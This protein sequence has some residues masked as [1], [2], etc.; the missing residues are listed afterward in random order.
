MNILNVDE[1]R[2]ALQALA[3]DYPG[4]ATLVTLPQPTHERQGSYALVIGKRPLCRSGGVMITSGMHG[5][6][7]GG[8]DIC[9]YFAADLLEAY[10]TGSALVY[11]KKAF[12]ADSIRHMIER[13]T[14]VVFPCV[15]PDGVRYSHAHPGLLWRKNRNP[16]DAVPGDSRTIG[17]DNCRNFD[18]LWDYEAA[19]A[20]AAIW[21]GMGSK[22][23]SSDQYHGRAPFSE[24]ETRNVRWLLDQY[25]Q[26]RH[27]LDLH[28]HSGFVIHP[29]GDDEN[30]YFSYYQNFR[31]NSWNGKRGV[32]GKPYGEY[33]CWFE[34]NRYKSVTGSISAAIA[35]VRGT[36]YGAYQLFLM[37]AFGRLTY[38]TSGVSFDWVYSR[39]LTERS[40]HKVW[41][42]GIEF[43]NDRPGH[44][45]I[46]GDELEQM[47]P[48]VSAGLVELCRR[49]TP[50]FWT[51]LLFCRWGWPF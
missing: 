5:R 19:F 50:G 13:M 36:I 33:M 42:Y 49:A 6:E 3:N 34:R 29:W 35:A 43:N 2:S 18:F 31:N 14:I 25:P 21:D 51:H 41:G 40:K 39:H 32:L 20:P 15:N 37:P 9:I 47:V 45:D 28:S 7:W 46:T 26:V 12:S 22:Y 16:T 24:P 8:P 10:A 1:I 11:E 17:V 48:D 27:Y 30:Q 38:C 23:P 4:L 44:F